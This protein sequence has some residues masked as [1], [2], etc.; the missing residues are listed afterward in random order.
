MFNFALNIA[1][2]FLLV[3]RGNIFTYEKQMFLSSLFAVITF[4]F[5]PIAVIF[6][7]GLTGF[8]ITSILMLLLGLFNSVYQS[9]MYGVCGFLP[10][11]FIIGASF[12]NGVAGMTM[13]I[14]RYIVVLI[15]GTS[16]DES[17]LLNGSLLFFAIATLLLTLGVIV[18]P[19]MFRDPYIMIN[20]YKSGE[21]SEEKI[22]EICREFE[23]EN[24]EKENEKSKNSDKILLEEDAIN[25]S[26]NNNEEVK[27]NIYYVKE[28]WKHLYET[29]MSIFA[30]FL[31]TFAIYPGLCFNLDLL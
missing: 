14:I 8:I 6:I 25:N 16:N 19:F 10:F 28:L 12:G 1:F 3:F 21:V 30:I 7:P 31:M 11:T 15:F 9:S 13:G 27:T 24:K 26:N 18:I 5:I 22:S 23:I 29:N 4:V 17:T 20:M 2:Q